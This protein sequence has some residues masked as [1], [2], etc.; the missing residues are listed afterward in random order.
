MDI[1][2]HVVLLL[3]SFIMLF[4]FIWMISTSLKTQIETLAYPPALFPAKPQWENYKYV[5]DTSPFMKFYLNSI[6]VTVGVVVGQLVTC[7]MGAYAFS[8]RKFRGR[9]KLFVAYLAT[10]MVPAQVTMI[11]TYIIISKLKWIDTYKALIIPC[12]F[13]AYGTFLLRQF[14]MGIPKDLE[15][16]VFIDGGGAYTCFFHIILP[17]TKTALITFGTFVFQY[18]WNNYLWPL[19]VTNELRM[20]TLPMGIQFFVGQFTTL[21]HYMMAAATMAM[22]PMIFVYLFAQRYFTAGIAITGIKA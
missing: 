15:E 13:S 18:A 4:P 3:G 20:F 6:I 9:D 1:L 10:M 11:P 7:S 22:V 2:A 19:L 8:R 21:Y 12:I 16:S 17:L 14:F 5:F